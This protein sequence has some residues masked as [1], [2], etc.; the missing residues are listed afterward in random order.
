MKTLQTH[1]S[2]NFSS[3][4]RKRIKI[5]KNTF[6]ERTTINSHFADKIKSPLNG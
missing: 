4:V 1:K 5:K 6:R 2:S 3:C